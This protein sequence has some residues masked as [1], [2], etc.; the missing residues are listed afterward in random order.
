MEGVLAY[1]KIYLSFGAALILISFICMDIMTDFLNRDY[2]KKINY[3]NKLD[4]LAALS[5]KRN[6]VIKVSF[7]KKKE[8]C[9]LKWR[10]S[11]TV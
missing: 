2:R 1:W 6:G 11:M 10:I 7:Q 5:L 9:S 4:G 8:N 3:M